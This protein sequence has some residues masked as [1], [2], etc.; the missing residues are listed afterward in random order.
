MRCDY[1]VD[2][3]DAVDGL[4]C[5]DLDKPPTLR[6]MKGTHES[7]GHPN[8]E[9]HRRWRKLDMNFRARSA[10]NFTDEAFGLLRS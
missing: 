5:R 6:S 9:G 10:L 7:A 1:A 2:A 4:N 8:D 3:V